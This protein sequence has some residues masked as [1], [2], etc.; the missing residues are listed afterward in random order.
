M[1][2]MYI[3]G[4]FASIHSLFAV[5]ASTSG[6][7]INKSKR[8]KWIALSLVFGFVGHFI[9]YALQHDSEYKSLRS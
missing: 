6:V 3:L 4:L 2:E 7:L 8:G 5:K 9:Y 1:F